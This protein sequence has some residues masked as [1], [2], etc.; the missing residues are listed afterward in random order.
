M[1]DFDVEGLRDND[2][3]ELDRFQRR[4][5]RNG[6]LISDE[7]IINKYNTNLMF[8]NEE[9]EKEN[10]RI[11]LPYRMESYNF[12]P[13]QIIGYFDYDPLTEKPIILK[14]KRTGKLVDKNLRHV[15]QF[16]FLIDDL[17]NI[18]DNEGHIKMKLDKMT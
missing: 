11:P 14:S 3:P 4:I 12:N 18:I 8:S 17:G 6:Y 13:H 5:N 9:I 7:G 15:N 16:G 1:G 10:G 2:Y